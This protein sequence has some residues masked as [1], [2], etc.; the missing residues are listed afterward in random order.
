MIKHGV[1][2]NLSIDIHS[3]MEAWKGKFKHFYII[4][5]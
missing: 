4:K 2:L 1:W 3:F 5:I